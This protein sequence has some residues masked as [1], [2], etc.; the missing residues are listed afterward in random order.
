VLSGGAVILAGDI[1]GTR[2]RFALVQPGKPKPIRQGTLESRTFASLE[3]AIAEFLGP[4]PPRIARATLG[5]AGP[6][7]NNRCTATNLPWVIDGRAIAKKLRIPRVELI[8]DL[9][10]ISFGALGVGKSKLEVLQGGA[11]KRSGKNL[12]ILAAGTGLGEAALV[13]DAAT[14]RYVP[15]G[16]EGGHVD[17]APRDALEIDLLLYLQKRFGGHVSYERI[18]SGPGLG[19]LYDFFHDVRGV[20]ETRENEDR[21]AASG[22]RNAEIS[23]LG[24]AR[25][26]TAAALAIERFASLYGAE[27][28]N[29]ALKTLSVGGVFVAGGISAFLAPVLAR[30]AF[31][32]AFLDKGRFRPLL[33]KVPVAIVKDSTIGL[34]GSAYH[35]LHIHQ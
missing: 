16:T 7:V 28:G 25:S 8:N 17:F 33:E 34:A 21:L 30:G 18:V 13:W 10:A 27:A 20:V 12:A 2:A 32:Q 15:L 1:G 26:S 22:D 31:L 6:V 3:D 24:V 9:V 4:K 14:E 11:P 19:V 35:A 23:K 29:L 5:V